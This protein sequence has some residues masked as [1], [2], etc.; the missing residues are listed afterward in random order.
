[1]NASINV[2]EWLGLAVIL[3]GLETFIPAGFF[4]WIGVSGVG[5]ALVLWVL[6]DISIW[7]QFLIFAFF[8]V[9]S[10]VASKKLLRKKTHVAGYSTLNERAFHYIGRTFTLSRPIVN[11]R[12]KVRVE[13]TEWLAA[14]PDLPQGSKVRVIEVEGTLLKVEKAEE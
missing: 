7:F 11:G 2:W 12:G 4:L 8:S 9:L 6:P 14:G 3:I 10:I 13:D 5:V 1:M